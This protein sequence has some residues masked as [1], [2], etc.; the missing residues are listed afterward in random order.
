M[1]FASFFVSEGRWLFRGGFSLSDKRYDCMHEVQRQRYEH[2]SS[3][4]GDRRHRSS[5][6]SIVFVHVV[7]G[8]AGETAAIAASLLDAA[9]ATREK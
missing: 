1:L 6:V 4:T 9:D 2:S 8:A 5:D 3:S 7:L